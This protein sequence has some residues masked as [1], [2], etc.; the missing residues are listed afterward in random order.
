MTAFKE[1]CGRSRFF[2]ILFQ[3]HLCHRH[4]F[5][6]SVMISSSKQ[7]HRYCQLLILILSYYDSYLGAGRQEFP[8][9]ISLRICLFQSAYVQMQQLPGEIVLEAFNWTFKELF[10]Q[11]GPTTLP[12]SLCKSSHYVLKP[13][14]FQ[15]FI[16]VAIAIS[17]NDNY[18]G[19][20]GQMPWQV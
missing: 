2:F 9:L 14:G 18:G 20:K 6:T 17:Q 1:W 11:I 7:H 19:K 16:V 4:F 12:S 3:I 8:G 13:I 10:S 15:I 5:N